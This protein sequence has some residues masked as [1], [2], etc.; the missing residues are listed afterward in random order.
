MRELRASHV[1]A[2]LLFTAGIAACSRQ[3]VVA[4]S[5]TAQATGT[6]LLTSDLNRLNV[7]Q[8]EY[9]TA[10]GLYAGGIADLEFTPSDGISVSVIQGDDRGYSAIASDGKNEC[11]IYVG[12][13]RSPRGYV[14]GP[15]VVFCSG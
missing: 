8:A 3:A 6:A 15:N 2:L 12:E 5:P 1:L 14:S 7:Q 10:N 13:V 11:A 4:D 9:M